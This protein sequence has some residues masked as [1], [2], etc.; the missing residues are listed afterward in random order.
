MF[1]VCLGNCIPCVLALDSDSDCALLR[2]VP[3]LWG[4]V[5]CPEVRGQ[6]T[7]GFTFCKSAAG[8]LGTVARCRCE[9][10]T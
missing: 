6:A 7:E 4:S 9:G 5:E 3:A 10:E 2:N 8:L 1:V